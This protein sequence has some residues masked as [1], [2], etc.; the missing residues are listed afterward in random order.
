[1]KLFLF[2]LFIPMFVFSQG[3]K[4]IKLSE[5]SVVTE[6]LDTLF[7]LNDDLGKRIYLSWDIDA[8]ETDKNR[9]IIIMVDNLPL[10]QNRDKNYRVERKK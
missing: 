2:L 4:Y 8:D 6:K 9:P 3:S 1:M 7:L 10:A 5:I